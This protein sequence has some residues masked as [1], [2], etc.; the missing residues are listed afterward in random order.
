[1]SHGDQDI[2]TIISRNK[3]NFTASVQ[4][5]HHLF[6]LHFIQRRR[7]RSYNDT[8][9][10]HTK[11][12]DERILLEMAFTPSRL[13]EYTDG[14]AKLTEYLDQAINKLPAL[15][16]VRYHQ[17]IKA[18][19]SEDQH[20]KELIMILQYATLK[21]H[22]Q[23]SENFWSIIDGIFKKYHYLNHDRTYAIRNGI[24]HILT[25]ITKNK[26]EEY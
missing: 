16:K 9:F 13:D 3:N 22:K 11:D 12:P 14:D 1:M 4:N 17:V 5:I 2:T 23:I 18:H 15:T 10:I 24:Y 20:D 6:D 26:L 8:I 21:F 19:L 7:I 25:I